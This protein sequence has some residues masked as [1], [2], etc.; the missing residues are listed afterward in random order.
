[1]VIDER[2]YLEDA[3]NFMEREFNARVHICGEE[4]EDPAN[5]RRH[6]FPHRPAIFMK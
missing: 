6:A 4:C 5:K 3:K 1:M 2:S